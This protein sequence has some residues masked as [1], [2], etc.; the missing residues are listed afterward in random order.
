M[1]EPNLEVNIAGIKM[2]NPVMAASGTFGYGTEYPEISKYKLD[3]LGAIVLKSVTLN[4]RPGN[5]PVRIA[6]TSAGMLNSIGLQNI[7]VEALIKEKLPELKS[8]GTNV[9]INIAGS[10][11]DEYVEVAKIVSRVKEVAGLEIN[12]SCPNVKKGGLAFGTDPEVI[13]E[14][15]GRVKEAAGTLAVIA[16]LTPN[17][18][19]VT[20]I[21]RAAAEAGAD[22]ISLI[23]TVLGMAIDIQTKRPVLE[24][25]TGG[26]SGPAIKPI[27]LRMVYQVSQAFKE[28]GIKIPIIGLGGIWDAEDA[29][30]FIIAGAN[31]IQIG[32]ANFH[33]PFV[34]HK[35]ISGIKEFLIKERCSDINCLVGSLEPHS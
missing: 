19:D 8:I 10:T 31:A 28:E 2:K 15:I 7:G 4:P 23:N 1:K 12:I 29:L 32:T 3:E 13:R 18:T 5:P 17:V 14:L 16:K 21:A 27:A 34:C 6:E 25:N 24:S 26:L 9:I 11:I 33:D 22:A 30:S 20:L 35:V